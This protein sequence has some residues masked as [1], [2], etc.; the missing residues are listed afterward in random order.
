MSPLQTKIKILGCSICGGHNHFVHIDHIGREDICDL[1]ASRED[2]VIEAHIH[3]MQFAY[4]QK[5][6]QQLI[7]KIF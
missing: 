4:H 7:E 2:S 1:C 5:L 6:N 3:D